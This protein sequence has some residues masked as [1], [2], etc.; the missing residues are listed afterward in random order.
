MTMS[1][2][3][4][5]SNQHCHVCW[6]TK[7]S[8]ELINY[9]IILGSDSPKFVHLNNLCFWTNNTMLLCII[10]R[11]SL[12]AK[13]AKEENNMSYKSGCSRKWAQ[14]IVWTTDQLNIAKQQN[15][16]WPACQNEQKEGQPSWPAQRGARQSWG[17]IYLSIHPS[18]SVDDGL[19][20]PEMKTQKRAH[21]KAHMDM[22]LCDCKSL[23][24][25]R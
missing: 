20:L 11:M 9:L 8:A 12:Q 13:E 19:N 10:F 5:F 3:V 15:K 25:S 2:I 16:K 18:Q 22:I 17:A 7:S 1:W 14:F 6:L 4:L 24:F 23:F 21:Q